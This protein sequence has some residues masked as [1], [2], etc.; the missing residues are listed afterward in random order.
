M[1]L[2]W[3]RMAPRRRWGTRRGGV[4]VGSARPRHAAAK[5]LAENAYGLGGDA[6][7]SG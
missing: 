7:G 6:R 5:P 3:G 4:P 1:K 2:R